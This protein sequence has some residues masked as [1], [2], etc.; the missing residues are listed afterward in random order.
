MPRATEEHRASTAALARSLLAEALGV[1]PMRYPAALAQDRRRRWTPHRIVQTVEYFMQHEGHFPTYTE[2]KHPTR[3][4][5]PALD[6]IRRYWGSCEALHHA[7]RLRQSQ[8]DALG[9]AD[10]V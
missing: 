10:K 2:W 4:D 9:T 6:T 7:V 8:R 1:H 3:W 5:L